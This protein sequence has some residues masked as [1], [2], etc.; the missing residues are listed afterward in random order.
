MI[1]LKKIFLDDLAQPLF[2]K[3]N[4]KIKNN[5]NKKKSNK[6]YY[7][8]NRSPGS[9]MFSNINYVLNHIKYAMK[10]NMVPIIDMENFTTIYNEKEKIFH[11]Y[12]AWEYYFE[13]ITNENLKNI[14]NNK[15]FIL[16]ENKN[17]KNFI[18]RLDTDKTIIKLFREL[19]FKKY[20]LN[21]VNFFKKKFFKK[22]DTVLGV[23]LRS[24]TYK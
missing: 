1:N 20:L 8:I 17:L 5:L 10:N 23:Q 19:K 7:V 13:Q 18:N 22:K 6:N 3:D 2:F 4:L 9:G 24:T 15:N 16:S 14:Y 11:T 12:N 21:E